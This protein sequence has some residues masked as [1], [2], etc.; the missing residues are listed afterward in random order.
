VLALACP[1]CGSVGRDPVETQVGFCNKCREFT[2]LCGAGRRIVC[3][4]VMTTTSWHVPCT[5][6]GVAAWEITVGKSKCKTRLCQRHDVQVAA[7]SATW[8]ICARRLI[9]T[10]DPT[11]PPTRRPELAN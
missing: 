8:I 4:D 1:D 5:N 2:G 6:L 9:T 3:P 10:A 7:G 11:T